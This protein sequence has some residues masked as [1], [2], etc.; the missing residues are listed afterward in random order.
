MAF[1]AQELAYLRSQPLA[2]LPPG[3]P[4][5]IPGQRSFRMPR[6]M[7]GVAAAGAAWTA[8]RFMTSV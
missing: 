4:H 2:R 3:P 8:R 1:T 7:S 5:L 6:R